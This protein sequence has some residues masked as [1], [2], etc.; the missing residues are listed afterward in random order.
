MQHDQ[1]IDPMTAAEQRLPG[2]WLSEAAQLG[3]FD[4]VLE[5]SRRAE[6]RVAPEVRHLDVAGCLLQLRFAGKPLAQSFVPALAHLTV[7]SEEHTS[8][9][10]SRGLISY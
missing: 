1:A 5:R 4:E 3:F 8:E 9:L 2:H 6:A 7:T 10:Q